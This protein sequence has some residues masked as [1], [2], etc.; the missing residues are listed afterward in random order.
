MTINEFHQDPIFL[1]QNIMLNFTP[2]SF[3]ACFRVA[4]EH[5]SNLRKQSEASCIAMHD[6]NRVTERVWASNMGTKNSV[7]EHIMT[8]QKKPKKPTSL[9]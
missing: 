9:Y 8:I 4:I 6:G 1:Q 2:G 3:E 7:G 5:W